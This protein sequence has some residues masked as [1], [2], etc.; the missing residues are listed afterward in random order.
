MALEQF[1][2]ACA[3]DNRFTEDHPRAAELLPVCLGCNVRA[4]C[5]AFA[6]AAR[7]EVGFWAG[8]A[9]PLPSEETR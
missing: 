3:G 8:A 6:A 4:A 2:A 9:Y 5:A 1:P 7:P